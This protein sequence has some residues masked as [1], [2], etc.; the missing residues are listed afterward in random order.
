LSKIF[1]FRHTET[2]DNLNHIFSGLRDVPLTNQGIL[3]AKQLAGKLRGE[4][5]EY[6][7]TSPLRRTIQTMEIILENYP[8]CINCVDPRIIE[9]SYGWLEGQSKDKWAVHSFRLFKMF[10]RSMLIPPPGGE[11]L[12]DVKNRVDLFIKDVVHLAKRYQKN[13][14]I[15]THG[16]AIRGI[17]VYFESLKKD[18]FNQIE[19]KIG[20]LFQYEV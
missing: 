17:R 5:I 14:V 4:K 15:C 3:G 2:L 12:A 18:Q 20:D 13:I 10:H 8:Q 16:N 19:T 9:R 11:S 6:A 7:F 1:V